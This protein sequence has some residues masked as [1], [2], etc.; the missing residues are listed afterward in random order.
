MLP[1]AALV[2]L[3]WMVMVFPTLRNPDGQLVI[4]ILNEPQSLLQT[5]TVGG[6]VNPATCG[7]EIPSPI[8]SDSV[9]RARDEILRDRLSIVAASYSKD[10]SLRVLKAY[11]QF[12]RRFIILIPETPR[13][14]YRH[15]R[16]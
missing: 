2:T 12:V 13:E 11:A 10:F 8:R 16:V 15:N 3:T 14:P 7:T 9:T 1:A 6:R 5:P 4:E